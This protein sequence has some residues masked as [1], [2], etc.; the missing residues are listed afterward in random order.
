M[1]AVLRGPAHLLALSRRGVLAPVDV[2]V[3]IRLSALAGETSEAAVLALARCVRGVRQGAVVLDLA[4]VPTSVLAAAAD[5][6][7]VRD[8]AAGTPDRDSDTGALVWPS[9]PDWRAALDASPL[10]GTPQRLGPL[11]REGDLLW[12]D[13]SWR[14]EVAVAQ[15]LLDRAA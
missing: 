8:P 12:L 15:D 13:A 6:D 4:S 11:H 3:A 14:Q 2:H 5:L 10:V 7:A 1:T 9:L